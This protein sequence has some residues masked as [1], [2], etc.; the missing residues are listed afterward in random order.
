MHTTV[1]Q[2]HNDGAGPPV[3][4]EKTG[5]D[6]RVSA[7]RQRA[8]R[9]ATTAAGLLSLVL[10][11]VA[12]THPLLPRTGWEW[13]WEQPPR[14]TASGVAASTAA[15]AGVGLVIRAWRRPL[16]RPQRGLV[17]AILLLVA[18][19]ASAL[20]FVR[21]GAWLSDMRIEII[22]GTGAPSVPDGSFPGVAR[23]LRSLVVE[24]PSPAAGEDKQANQHQW[25][26][27]EPWPAE[28][29]VIGDPGTGPGREGAPFSGWV[30]SVAV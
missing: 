26:G 30:G 16:R 15:A 4:P 9:L 29:K 13:S 2:S 5:K 17:F 22:D 6:V 12:L 21:S 28:A 7:Q 23:R 24:C 14:A 1:R 3:P 19:A 27:Q 10:W 25:N 20:M 8:V 18:T 11:A